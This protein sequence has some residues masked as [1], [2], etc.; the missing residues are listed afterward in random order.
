MS[1]LPQFL[2]RDNLSLWSDSN[3]FMDSV[4]D[5]WDLLDDLLSISLPKIKI[6]KTTKVSPHYGIGLGYNP[7]H[8]SNTGPN[9]TW[10]S[11]TRNFGTA[12]LHRAEHSP[13]I[14]RIYTTV[15][16]PQC[17]DHYGSCADLLEN[18]E[19][20]LV[21]VCVCMCSR[22]VDSKVQRFH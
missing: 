6:G 13:H 14:L 16:H 4:F 8:H 15:Q 21:G 12:N 11:H 10:I 19:G 5:T 9:Q 2:F 20:K 18:L 1:K 3:W 22:W 7:T 17:L